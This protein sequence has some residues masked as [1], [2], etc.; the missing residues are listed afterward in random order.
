MPAPEIHFDKDV[1]AVGQV[2]RVFASDPGWVPDMAAF[3]A[4][5]GIASLLHRG[6]AAA[7]RRR[8]RTSA[9][10]GAPGAPRRCGAP[11]GCRAK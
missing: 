3:W 9:A 5:P 6:Q 2:P 4:F 8:F 11:R 7:L 1:D 10:P